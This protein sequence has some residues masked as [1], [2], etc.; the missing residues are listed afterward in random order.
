MHPKS[1][2]RTKPP[3]QNSSSKIN[4]LFVDRTESRLCL[5]ILLP[6]LEQKS[7][8]LAKKQGNKSDKFE[9][10]LNSLPPAKLTL[11]GGKKR[12]DD[13]FFDHE[14]SLFDFSVVFRRQLFL[15]SFKLGIFFVFS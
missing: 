14:K 9:S 10:E 7:R 3:H 5:D 12:F 13:D 6:A 2:P 11:L 4:S 1:N 15:F 8:K